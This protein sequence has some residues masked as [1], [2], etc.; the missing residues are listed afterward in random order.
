MNRIQLSTPS[1]PFPLLMHYTLST[2]IQE[3]EDVK[4][5]YNDKLQITEYEARLVGTRSLKSSVT[6]KK[7]N[8]LMKTMTDRKN[9]IDDQ[10]SAL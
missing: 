9:E 10:K 2:P 6:T 8:G 7:V 4:I 3:A 1:T 5:V